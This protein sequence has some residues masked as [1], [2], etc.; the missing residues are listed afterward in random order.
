MGGTASRS[1]RNIAGLMVRLSMPCRVDRRLGCVRVE[2]AQH[3]EPASDVERE[4]Q[5]HHATRVRERIR[6]EV[7]WSPVGRKRSR[8]R[9]AAE[10]RHRRPEIRPAAAVGEDDALRRAGR[11]RR[12]EDERRILIRDITRNRELR[13]RRCVARNAR[14]VDDG[15]VDLHIGSLVDD[16]GGIGDHRPGPERRHDPRHLA[17]RRG[18]MHRDGHTASQPDRDQRREEPFVVAD[19]HDHPATRLHAHGVERARGGSRAGCELTDRPRAF[20]LDPHA[21]VFRALG[22]PPREQLGE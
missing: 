14:E 8:V 2:L 3:H 18:W 16:V 19:P 15:R 1:I 12:Q 22:D 7:R 17:D 4:E 20:V 5:T 9:V 21:R 10:G 6:D 13:E 11:P